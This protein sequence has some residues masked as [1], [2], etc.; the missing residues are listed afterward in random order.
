M[1]DIPKEEI[2]KMFENCMD[3]FVDENAIYMTLIKGTALTVFVIISIIII[4]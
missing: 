1:G 4:K 2:Y 3:N